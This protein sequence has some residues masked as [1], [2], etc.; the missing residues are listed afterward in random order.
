M[1]RI[2]YVVAYDI[3]DDERRA[4]V[5]TFLSGFGPRVQLSVFEAELPDAAAAAD[6]RTRLHTMIDQQD[7]QVRLYRLTPEAL[8]QRIIYG[9]RRIEERV[10]YWIV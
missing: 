4:D 2:T 5:A 10:D 7:D 9:S 8:S 3:V 1:I 6:F